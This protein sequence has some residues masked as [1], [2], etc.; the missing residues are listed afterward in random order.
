MKVPG[1]ELVPATSSPGSSCEHQLLQIVL[2]F[3]SPGQDEGT[4]PPDE[5]GGLGGPDDPSSPF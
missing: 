3:R 5:M 1:E 2:M 4:S